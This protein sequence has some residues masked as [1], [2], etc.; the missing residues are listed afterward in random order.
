[1]TDANLIT[2]RINH[3]YYLG[4]ALTVS[5]E[6]A[7]KAM[8]PIAEHFGLSVAD[9]AL[10]VIRVADGHMVNAI[11][12][13][14]VRRGYDPRDFTLVAMGGGG[15]M[16]AAAL[17]RELRIGQV[18]IPISPGTF[19][20]WGMLVSEPAQDFIRTRVIRSADGSRDEMSQ[21]FRDIEAEA[22]A[23]M[24]AAGYPLDRLTYARSV[25]MR[26]AGQEH[27]VRI[28]L[29]GELDRAG[30]EARFHEAHERAYTYRLETG[31][32]FVNFQITAIVSQPAPDLA[33]YAP[34]PGA[35][36][37][38][39]QMRRVA[40]DD[41]VFDTTVYAREEMPAEEV[42]MGPAIIEEPSATTV[43]HP[44]HRAHVDRLGN[45]ML[46]LGV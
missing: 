40:F 25:D 2:N 44:G 24:A 19:S 4:G 21:L 41:G 46:E 6:A 26:Y 31:I 11:K 10:G 39:K 35:R 42:V 45:L 18:L 9:A 3:E 1:V 37:A 28:P 43:V 12:L 29:G 23:F 22:H 16:H 8:T 14:S 36:L 32:E 20:A 34:R 27:T 5:V 33:A 13:V 7:T 38:P 17:A 30:I 15:P